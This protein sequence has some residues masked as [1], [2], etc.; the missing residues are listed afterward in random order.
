[1]VKVGDKVRVIVDDYAENCPPGSI[2]T[3]QLNSG[4]GGIMATVDGGDGFWWCFFEGEYEPTTTAKEQDYAE[5]VSEN[6][7]K[8][9]IELV[10]GNVLIFDGTS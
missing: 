6:G 8:I 7:I 3:V 5:Q 10:D 1:M 2:L 9:T 4:E